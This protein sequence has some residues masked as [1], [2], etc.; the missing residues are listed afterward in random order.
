MDK[1]I[2][3]MANET[4]CD[5]FIL[6]LILTKVAN[7]HWI[8]YV[9]MVDGYNIKHWRKYQIMW[10]SQAVKSSIDII[11]I[12]VYISC[13]YVYLIFKTGR[14][15]VWGIFQNTNMLLF[16]G[17]G[18]I[19]WHYSGITWTSWHLKSQATHLFVLICLFCSFFRIT[20]KTSK[21]CITGPLG[22]E[23]TG[24]Q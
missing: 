21:F 15:E 19:D 2:T 24:D 5:L 9:S 10:S 20:T 17:W 6:Q 4:S 3:K 23:S 14:I 12:I 18:M 7:N 8:S 1:M 13:E 11:I 22:Q 16:V